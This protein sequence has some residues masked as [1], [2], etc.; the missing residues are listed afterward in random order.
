[1]PQPGCTHNVDGQKTLLRKFKN[2]KPKNIGEIEV[3]NDSEIKYKLVRFNMYSK[4]ALEL[5]LSKR[6]NLSSSRLGLNVIVFGKAIQMM[7]L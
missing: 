7:S 6:N 1:M 3:R 5:L 4:D 2:G